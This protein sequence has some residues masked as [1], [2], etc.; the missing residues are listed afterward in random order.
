MKNLYL[1]LATA[2][3]VLFAVPLSAQQLSPNGITQIVSSG[4]RNL[5]VAMDDNNNFVMVYNRNTGSGRQN[6]IGTKY[7]VDN[8]PNNIGDLQESYFVEDWTFDSEYPDVA[9]TPDGSY[10]VIAWEQSSN[11]DGSGKGIYARVYPDFAQ[12]DDNGG[13][14]FLVNTTTSGD[15]EIPKVAMA[16]DGDFLVIW[17]SGG[18]SLRGQRFNSS[19]VKQGSEFI[20]A[21]ITGYSTSAHYDVA[22]DDGGD[23]VV[24]WSSDNDEDLDIYARLYSASATPQGSAFRVNNTTNDLQI[25]PKVA[26]TG[27]GG[28]VIYWQSNTV[29]TTHFYKKYY[30]N[31]TVQ[32]SDTEIPTSE[33]N[34]YIGDVVIND[35]G[36]F[37]ISYTSLDRHTAYYKHFASNGTLVGSEEVFADGSLDVDDIAMALNKSTHEHVMI[38]YTQGS[39]AKV[40]DLAHC[41]LQPENLSGPTEVCYGSTG[42]TY[43]ISPVSG[44]SS[45]VWSVPSGATI[46]ENNGTS[47][48]VT[49]G[50]VDGQVSVYA[51]GSCGNSIEASIDVDVSGVLGTPG[52]I[53]GPTSV[54]ENS[55]NTYS[56]SAV[57]N[58][59]SYNWTLPTGAEI[60]TDNGNQIIVQFGTTSGT[61]SVT[62]SDECGNT[63]SASNKSVT[64]TAL[65]ET[66]PSI[67][68]LN[69]AHRSEGVAIGR[70][71]YSIRFD[72][73]VSLARTFTVYLKTAGAI[74]GSTVTVGTAAQS[75]ITYLPKTGYSINFTTSGDL[76][77]NKEYWIEIP[78]GAFSDSQ[79]NPFPGTDASSWSFTANNPPT[80]IALSNNTVDEN[81]AVGA[82]VGTLSGTDADAGE[83][84]NFRLATGTGGDDN[85][86]FSIVDNQLRIAVSP[87]FE[88]GSTRSILIRVTDGA[89]ETYDEVFTI[90][91]NDLDETAPTLSSRSPTDNETNVDK[92]TDA[93]IEFDEPIRW[94]QDGPTTI[95]LKR[96]TLVRQTWYVNPAT[97]TYPDLASIVGSQLTLDINVNLVAEAEHT[98]SGFE[99]EDFGGNTGVSPEIAFTIRPAY[100]DNDILSFDAD[101]IIGSAVI[102]TENHTVTAT[103]DGAYGYEVNPVVTYSERAWSN[104][105]NLAPH[106]FENGVEKDFTVTAEDGS[107]QIW[108][109]T[110][111]WQP[112]NG[113]FSVGAG[114]HYATLTE[115][116]DDIVDRGISGDITLELM[117][118]HVDNGTFVTW[119]RYSG[120]DAYTTTITVA[121]GATNVS[122]R[123][124][125][126]TFQGAQ[127]MVVDGKG[128]LVIDPVVLGNKNFR[129]LKD[130]SD[131]PSENITIKNVKASSESGLVETQNS[132]NILIHNNDFDSEDATGVIRIST[133]SSNVIA[134]SNKIRVSNSTTYA[135]GFNVIGT[136][137]YV[138]IYNNSV[139]LY[140]N[141]AGVSF[142]GVTVSTH[143]NLEVYNNTFVS[144]GTKTGTTGDYGITLSIA[145][146]SDIIKNNLFSYKGSNTYTGMWLDDESTAFVIEDN[147]L[148]IPFN[149]TYQ[150]YLLY[151]MYYD[152][153]D[154]EAVK[155]LL[156]KLTFETVNFTD[157][158]NGDLSLSGSS[159][160]SAN[161][162]GS[163]IALVE[164]DILGNSRSA[165][166]PSKGAYESSNNIT[167]ITAF[168]FDNQIG[169]PVIDIDN[170]TVQ[171][172]IQTGNSLTEITPTITTFPGSVISPASGV[173]QDFSSS[174]EYTL[175]AED[176]TQETW[177][178]TITEEPNNETDITAFSFAEQTGNATI[179]TDLH[180]VDIEVAYGTNVNSLSPTIELSSGAA[181]SPTG[182][183]DFSSAFEYTVTAED[184]TTTQVW[185]INV[186][187][188]PNDETDI[189]TFTLPQQAAPATINATAHTV[190]IAV[191]YGT[192][193]T[194][195]TPVIGLSPGAAISPTGSQDFSSSFE[196][197]VTAED[198]ITSQ[199]WTVNISVAPNTAAQI[200]SFSF[201]E[202]TGPATINTF[203]RTI[204]IEVANGTNLTS[205]TPTIGISEGA[206]ITP[207]EA[208]DFST[209]VEYTVTAEDGETSLTWTVTV[210]EASNTNTD[211]TSFTFSEQ[212]GDAL[213][214]PT[215]HSVEIEVAY[216]TDL[217]N[218]TPTIGLSSGA[219][220]SPT[221]SRSF[222]S[223]VYYTVTAEDGETT[224]IWTVTVSVE[225]NDETDITTF[226]L[227]D[228]TGAATIN[229]TNHTVEIEVAYGTDVSS[230]TPTIGL[231]PGA[232]VSPTGSQNFST[233]VNYTVTAEDGETSQVWTATVTV[234]P[235]DETDITSFVL[236]DQTS[237]AVINTTD[238]TVD[239]QVAYGTDVSGLNP[240]IGLSAGASI[241]PTGSRDF[242]S[243]VNYTVTAEDETTSQ[244]WMVTVTVAPNEETD[245]TSFS[246]TEQTGLSIINSTNHTVDIEVAYGTDVSNL[247]P[248][249]G[250]SSGASIT[251]NGSRDFSSSV[252][253]T[254]TAED[255][256]TSQVWTVNVTIAPN[257][258]TDITSFELTAQTGS[259]AINSTDHTVEIEVEFGTD[260]TN[261]NPTFGL[262]D[263]ASVSPTGAG[264]FTNPVSYTVTAEDGT[265]IQ[266]WT[267]T[268]TVA[269]NVET[270]ITSF[271]LAA[272]TGD[273]TIDATNH[274][275]NVEVAHG[276]NVV[277]MT[278]TIGLSSGASISPTGS[279]DFS[280]AVNYTV[281]AEDGSTTQVWTVNVTISPNDETDISSF[282][283]AAQTGVATI[284]ATNHTVDI[285]VDYGTDVSSLTPTIT[286]SEGA[287]ISPSGSRDFS[288]SVNYTVTAEDGSTTQLWTVTVAIAP[289]NETD[290]VSFDL[291]E[292]TGPAAID[293]TNHTVSIE[294]AFGTDVS[295]LIPTLGLSEGA[296]VSPTGAQD[297]GSSV[298]YTVTAEDGR[299]AQVW[300]VTVTVGAARTG[301]EIVSFELDEQTGSATID[302]TGKTVDI[303]ALFGT[304]LSSLVPAISISGGAA[305]SPISGSAQDF[306]TPVIY[307]VT[308]EDGSTQEWTVTVTDALNDK[309]DIVSFELD[310]QVESAVINS[311]ESTVKI[312]VSSGSDLSS[313]APTIVVSDS[314]TIDPSS[315]VSRD[316]TSDVTYTVT[317]ENGTTKE[318]TVSVSEQ[319]SADTEIKSFV[320]E[321]QTG[322]AE[323]DSANAKIG[324]EVAA[325]TDVTALSPTLT[326]SDGASSSPASGATVDF[327]DSVTYVVTAADGTTRNWK[328][329]VSTA[330]ALSSANDILSFAFEEQTGNAS[331][332]VNTH[333]ISIE[334]ASSTDLT[335]LVPTITVSPA[336]TISPATG[337]SQ[338]FSQ[339]VSYTVTAEDGSTQEWVVNVSVQVVLSSA[340][341]ILG[342]VLSE[343]ITDAIINAE[344]HTV[345]AVVANGTSLSSLTPTITLSEGASSNPESGVAVDFTNP[346]EYIITAEDGTEQSWVV[347]VIAEEVTGLDSEIEVTV[348]PNPTTDLVKLEMNEIGNGFIQLIS[349][350]GSL[351]QEKEL[352]P[353][354]VFEL[355][356]FPAGVY[357]IRIIK[358]GEGVIHNNRVLKVD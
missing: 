95:V 246:F 169:D 79:D 5:Q 189:L 3:F 351:L 145:G 12:D 38:G 198:E 49:L 270:D 66:P 24:T 8:D 91:I 118:G 159:L 144:N 258:E 86:D 302:A 94:K 281:T 187:I 101:G 321:E 171:A 99:V 305:I 27:T 4:A 341:D 348:Y 46:T 211:I 323:I 152:V 209:S 254:V 299:T 304:D 28:F 230:L 59:V 157:Y 280:S 207:T 111:N 15:Q 226:T 346:V 112:L 113:T 41:V 296:S 156:P 123:H 45:Y 7:I 64:V 121:D 127:N 196:Y 29:P 252:T 139:E 50:Q 143:E 42:N 201:T 67:L 153:N 142:S 342:F 51:S 335:N 269:P 148:E 158:G 132:T 186:T 10:H 243:A 195:L 222:F 353:A 261:L 326:L 316:F 96:G 122:T 331:I 203:A 234:A 217:S 19:G 72:E 37:F 354:Q 220:I 247:T 260:V 334:V 263:G 25:R 160:N 356:A 106:T 30:S 47:I 177:T 276:T 70:T 14:A 23:F 103:M 337:I 133:G 271:S 286:L 136:T 251:P 253:Y 285:E 257:D 300:S 71:V 31:A 154:L 347:N 320:L 17:L 288:N 264:D 283:L 69:P 34:L 130:A 16:A 13:P 53:S 175:T 146:T 114:G 202:Q 309:N 120:S 262:S 192:A 9:I 204:N 310:E 298:N 284:N 115:A 116:K 90:N 339:A 308:A 352:K 237:E 307:T 259:A 129:I 190:D 141:T 83:D 248:T 172:V 137:G 33:N 84:L 170:N 236:A 78:S 22:M 214:N 318:W 223:L 336:A 39:P 355:K 74:K 178:V 227:T 147:N 317:A 150:N 213:I 350:N 357:Y 62:A 81:V 332:V 240:N 293:A 311:T 181:I 322:N 249:I 306:N 210:I 301:K 205:L 166:A 224:Q 312:T 98:I 88:A 218:L 124:Y 324:I 131:N 358:T 241:T 216:G 104:L 256:S 340:N 344:N 80:D 206:E 265:T 77:P 128:I 35:A 225:P 277:G 105:T 266:N 313:L 333:T 199:V 20:I 155:S 238:H 274:T 6:I 183:Q 73:S 36:E 219:T 242:G 191:A 330:E 54:V 48:T 345:G 57:A 21:T 108:G 60:D 319:L 194:S 149:Y 315:G 65:D 140:T 185:T 338:D 68:S 32:I 117:D 193:L 329:G 328:V 208:Q 135:S 176:D 221:G 165:N 55:L 82:V 290:I 2:F 161:L 163:P 85:S 1:F 40:L 272:Q 233:P 289:N 349:S 245:I 164:T 327:S 93:Y 325:G 26:M 250:L 244:V 343:Q 303:E 109:I 182:A 173:S 100:T 228:Q 97:N 168:S 295:A 215:D 167:E 278:P 162:R 287:S 92:Y 282:S 268:V 291:S 134:H 229:A 239:I 292:K 61:V 297:F 212:T 255:E 107:P 188:E 151:D 179:N 267:I 43:S 314:A 279:R 58:A 44:A 126:M 11:A 89:G 52:T 200:T 56:V 119:P 231:S 18:S 110:L 174:V 273:A 75:A 180:T 294:V 138:R 63:S 197:T 235:N 125:N 275:I 102:D 184:N 76:T 232:S 87:D